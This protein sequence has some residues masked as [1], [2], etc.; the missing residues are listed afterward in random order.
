MKKEL[1][2]DYLQFY[3]MMEKALHKYNRCL[4]IFG[5][6]HKKTEHALL[7]LKILLDLNDEPGLRNVKAA[8]TLPQLS[9]LIVFFLFTI[10]E[11][12]VNLD[13]IKDLT[14]NAR[15]SNTNYLLLFVQSV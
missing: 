7:Q 8:L 6:Y 12:W 15:S 14:I 2:K 10:G 9:N 3:S 1:N 13:K 5:E 4:I 11:K